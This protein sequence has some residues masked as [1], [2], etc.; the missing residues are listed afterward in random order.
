M[1]DGT[2]RRRLWEGFAR[3]QAILG[4]H[5]RQGWVLEDDR[6]VASIVP[7]QPDSPALN[8]AVLLDPDVC[9][10][11][12]EELDH[13]Y[14][15]A[16]V[17]RWGIWLDS[18]FAQAA[19][20]LQRRGLSVAS[21]SPGMGAALADLPSHAAAPVE[22]TD[23]A[24]IGRINDAAYGN[25]DGRLARTLAA[26][27]S[28]AL[29]AFVVHHDGTPAACALAL[30]HGGD[31]GLSFVATLPEL[32][33]RGLASQIMFG[34]LDDAAAHGCTTV[35]LQATPQGQQL[36]DRLGLRRLGTMEL[37]ERR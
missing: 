32:R 26:L 19:R 18:A 21:A 10:E 1:D 14:K 3:L 12:F 30:H 29:R 6:L 23:L 37:W 16:G 5:G 9:V 4:G 35:T 28:D 36:Y 15:H 25:L 2:L 7:D 20:H 11:R 33:R 34:V 24:T 13:R 22:R 17:R 8:A 31:C 27:P